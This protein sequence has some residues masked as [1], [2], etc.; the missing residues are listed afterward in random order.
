MAGTL[1]I[2]NIPDIQVGTTLSPVRMGFPFFFTYGKE[3][4][5]IKKDCI[6]LPNGTSPDCLVVINDKGEESKL[7]GLVSSFK[8]VDTDSDE[9]F[10]GRLFAE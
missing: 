7:Y 5:V 1:S 3:Y 8:I 9:S 10:L 2:K 4:V 6:N